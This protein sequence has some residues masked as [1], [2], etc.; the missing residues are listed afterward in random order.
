MQKRA[1]LWL[2]GLASTP[3]ASFRY[4]SLTSCHATDTRVLQCVAERMRC[5]VLQCVALYV[6]CSVLQCVAVCCRVLQSVEKT[7]LSQ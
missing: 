5:G 1:T 7:S 4:V 6:C 2:E 3:E